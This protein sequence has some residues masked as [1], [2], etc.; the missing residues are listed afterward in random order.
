MPAD[1]ARLAQDCYEAYNI[2]VAGLVQR[3][4]ATGG[5]KIVIGVSGGLDSTQAL[6]V[7]AKAMDLLGLPRTDILAYTLP[8]F[9]TSDDT[10]ANAHRLMKA[11]GVTAEEL[12]IRPAAR[13][14]LADL[15]H[16]FGRGE[17]VYDVTFENVQAGL[18]T[19][20]LFRAANQHDGIVLGTG[21]LSELASAGAPTASATRCR[22]TTS[23]AACRR[24]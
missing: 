4:R 6:I 13:Q 1:P 19:D 8:G 23:T 12:D 24:R 10:K 5:G 2:Q 16:P 9:A 11:L 15:G 20:Y 7:A 21:D 17:P 18:R 22:T 14:M 3:L